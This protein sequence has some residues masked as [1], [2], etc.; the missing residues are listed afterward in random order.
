MSHQYPSRGPAAT[1]DQPS[2]A[3]PA[4]SAQAQEQQSVEDPAQSPKPTSGSGL[5]IKTFVE[6]KFAGAWNWKPKQPLSRFIRWLTT[7]LS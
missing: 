2:S 7:W 5:S 4:E 6:V 1:Q 3:R